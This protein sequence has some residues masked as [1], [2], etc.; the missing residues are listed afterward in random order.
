MSDTFTASKTVLINAKQTKI[1]AH[2]GLSGIECENTIAAY[3][4]AGNRNYFGI[5]TDAIRC[6]S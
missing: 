6:P 3:I 2:R 1:I 4:A 5:E